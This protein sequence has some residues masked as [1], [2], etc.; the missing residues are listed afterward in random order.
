MSLIQIERKFKK[1][2]GE[3]GFCQAHIRSPVPTQVDT[4][5][6]G[7]RGSD[8]AAV[9]IHPLSYLPIY[10]LPVV[11]PF[12]SLT[13]GDFSTSRWSQLDNLPNTKEKVLPVNILGI[14]FLQNTALVGVLCCFV[15]IF[16]FQN[17]CNYS[18]IYCI[19]CHAKQPR[20]WVNVISTTDYM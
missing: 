7:N 16:T 13:L 10:L 2:K 5:L 15:S 19:Y 1:R 20:M 17:D 11:V 8:F 4:Q 18:G 14:S 3:Q 9:S 12:L 6:G